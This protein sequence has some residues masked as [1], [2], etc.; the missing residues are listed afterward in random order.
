MPRNVD[1]RATAYAYE[2]VGQPPLR[3]SA[4]A[5]AYA[6]E[7]IS[8]PPARRSDGRA[9]TYAYEK[10]G[11][12]PHRNNDGRATSYAYERVVSADPNELYVRNADTGVFERFPLYTL[13]LTTGQWQQ[14]L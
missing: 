12:I 13:N 7:R 4:V 9:G 10:V 1:G 2:R 11:N 14:I 6:Y 5:T 8:E 3:A